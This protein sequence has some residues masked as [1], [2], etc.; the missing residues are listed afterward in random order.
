MRVGFD[1]GPITATRTGVGN[2]CYYL[3]KHLL[4][5]LEADERIVG[6]AT[7]R[8]RPSLHELES[9]LKYRYI[10]VPTRVMYRSWTWFNRPRVDRCL[11]GLDIYH[12]TNYFLPP[13]ESA[14]RVVT[15]HDLAFMATPELAS[16]KIVGPYS[17][18]MTTF[19]HEADAIMAYSESTKAD[20]VHYLDVP[21]EKITVAPMAVDEGFEPMPRDEAERWVREK[22]FVETPFLLFVSTLEPRKN[23]PTLLHAFARVA[24]EIPHKLVL[25][26]GIGWDSEEIFDTMRRLR[27]TDRVVRPGF[28]PHHELPAFYCAAD[29]FVFP[30][31]YEGFG[32]PLLEALTCGC[33]VITSN[34]SSVPEVTGDAALRS[35]ANDDENIAADIRRVLGN[36]ELVAEMKKRGFGHATKYSWDACARATLEVYRNLAQCVS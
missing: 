33:P 22:Y 30:T 13:T 10:P 31:L 20:I 9:R 28:V 1:I 15:I 12:A 17:R 11:G 18:Q 32:L 27:I 25:V 2:Y 14:K 6:F 29:A 5:L 24:R 21:P 35:D 19:A 16:P 36:P 4:R 23:V 34:N 3:L 8:E 7:G 26:G